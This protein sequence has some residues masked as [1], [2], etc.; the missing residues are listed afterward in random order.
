MTLK[1]RL[2]SFSCPHLG[3]SIRTKILVS[4]VLT[5]TLISIFIFTYYPSQQKQQLSAAIEHHNRDLAKLVAMGVSFGMG[6]GNFGAVKVALDAARDDENL[7]FM[8]L[9][10]EDG[11]V[12][13]AH[14]PNGFSL[15]TTNLIDSDR[16]TSIGGVDLHVMS[17]PVEYHDQRYG[18]LLYG[19]SLAALEAMVEQ[20]TRTTLLVCI[21]IL[22]FG[23]ASSSFFA[24]IITRPLKE[25]RDAAESIGQGNYDT[26]V[27]ITTSDEIGLTARVLKNMVEN[28]LKSLRESEEKFRSMT[29]SAQ[30]AIIMIDDEGS[31]SFWNDAAEKMLGYTAA[32]AIGQNCHNLLG[33]QAFLQD[34]VRGMAHF[35]DAGRSQYFNRIAEVT[36]VRKSG[37]EFPAEISLAPIKLAGQ[38]NAVAI[39]RDVSKLKRVEAELKNLGMAIDQSSEVVIVTDPKGI[40]TY[41]NPAFERVTGYSSE[42][43]LGQRPAILASGAH[44]A[45][46]FEDLWTTLTNRK[47]WKGHITNKR[48]DGSRYFDDVTISPVISEASEVVGYVA[49]QRDVT[50]ERDLE[51]HRKDLQSQLEKA[52]R[53]E[54]LGILA[55]GVAHDLNNMLGPIVGYSELVLMQTPEDSKLWRKISMINKAA[56]DAADVIQD[57]L[58]LARRGRY[59]MS[60]TNL[61]DVVTAYLESPGHVTLV[62]R[63]NDV[64][65]ELN[66][67]QKLPPISGSAPHLSKVIMN[68]IVNAFDAMPSGGQLLIETCVDRIDELHGGH[69]KIEPGEYV[70]LRTRDTGSGINPEDLSKIFEPYF[71]RKQ[72]G[73]SGS[74][75]GL[76]VVY[77]VVKD[78][79]GYYDVFSTVDAGTEFVLYFPVSEVPIEEP[80]QHDPVV[81]GNETILVVDDNNQQREMASEILSSLGYSAVSVANGH[82]AIELLKTRN[83]DLVLLDMVMDDDFDGLDTYLEIMKLATPPKVISYSAHAMTKRI[84]KM[85]ELGAGEFLRKPYTIESL[86]IAIRG[87]LDGVPASNEAASST[88][89]T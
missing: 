14:N 29:C 3:L 32:E 55:G 19:S 21:L 78:H 85:Q 65:I 54:S 17:V 69:D 12:F 49:V 5:L 52:K 84:L 57:L 75:L 34:A 79:Q 41:A 63:R 39:M 13:A 60:P 58:T 56:Q 50:V 51:S 86:G 1:Q 64:T 83:V 82:E 40:I 10:D 36:A 44:D 22:L 4:S 53:M 43:T 62:S 77:G 26:E 23:I 35:E 6:S 31:V 88:L 25:L 87:E 48:K 30:D 68:L 73:S 27:P 46:F 42:E 24:N 66:L 9:L 2:K 11:E 28:I 61:T 18:T 15:N 70:I 67:C 16:I 72:M 89:S 76:S 8:I 45:A 47:T 33:P 80:S 7:A 59:Q 71:S 74:G 38:W 81:R 20:N 37:E